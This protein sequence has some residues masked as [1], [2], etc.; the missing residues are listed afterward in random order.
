MDYTWTPDSGEEMPLINR[1]TDESEILFTI[2]FTFEASVKIIAMGFILG[3]T[4]YL[5]DGWN[6]L[7]LTVV[8]TALMENLSDME[9]VSALRT[10]R[11]FRP[12]RSLSAIPSMKLLMNTLM[13]SVS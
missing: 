11:L 4:C 1:I 6:W 13:S 2:F 7:D 5:R 8:I 3:N 10:F 9:N 12:L